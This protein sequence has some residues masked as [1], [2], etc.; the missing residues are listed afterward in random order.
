[1]LLS[2]PNVLT[3]LLLPLLHSLPPLSSRN[4][5]SPVPRPFPLPRTPQPFEKVRDERDRS[6]SRK[7]KKRKERDRAS[8]AAGG[9]GGVAGGD[10]HY[11]DEDDEGDDYAGAAAAGAAGGTGAGEDGLTASGVIPGS[12]VSVLPSFMDDLK[13]RANMPVRTVVEPALAVYTALGGK[14][15]S[16]GGAGGARERERSTGGGRGKTRVGVEPVYKFRL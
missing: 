12:H 7:S 5:P 10:D 4:P 15:K 6:S 2:P 14:A 8:R 13:T 16:G 11:G 1:M 9:G 3:C